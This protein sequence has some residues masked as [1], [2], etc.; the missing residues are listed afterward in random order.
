MAYRPWQILLVVVLAAW[1]LAACASQPLHTVDLN[2]ERFEVELALDRESQM[3]GL[4]FR[5]EMADNHGMLFIFPGEARRSFW[6]RNTRIPLDIF[7]F[8]A[9]L[10]LVSVAENARPCVVQDCP[11]Y[12]SAGPAQYVLEL[13]AGKARALDVKAGDVLKLNFDPESP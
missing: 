11:G 5:D 2:G 10:A 8:D 3:R 9:D 1:T 7:Y 12:P 13:N 6:M 4:M